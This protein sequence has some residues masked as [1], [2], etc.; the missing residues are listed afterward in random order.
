MTPTSIPV[1]LPTVPA[2]GVCCGHVRELE[3]AR[4]QANRLEDERDRLLSRVL[5]LEAAF[6]ARLPKWSR[7]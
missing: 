4:W 2:A 5:E 6:L 7:W 1:R 3:L